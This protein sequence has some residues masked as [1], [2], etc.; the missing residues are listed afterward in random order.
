MKGRYSTTRVHFKETHG[1]FHERIMWQ[2][3]WKYKLPIMEAE[4]AG[5]K[6]TSRPFGKDLDAY[7]YCSYKMLHEKFENVRSPNTYN[8]FIPNNLKL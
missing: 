6:R 3:Y 2:T 4:N 7:M 8:L 1:D 5:I